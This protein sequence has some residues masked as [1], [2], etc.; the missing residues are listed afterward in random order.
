[1]VQTGSFFS[2]HSRTTLLTTLKMDLDTAARGIVRSSSS[3]EK[4]LPPVPPGPG[5]TTPG[6]TPSGVPGKSHHSKT[7]ER[8]KTM[9]VRQTASFFK[10]ATPEE[11]KPAEPAK[12]VFDTKRAVMMNAVMNWS[13]NLSRAK[14]L[15]ISQAFNKWKYG[16][17]TVQSAADGEP[18]KEAIGEQKNSYL[19]LFR[20]NEK[21]RQQL[22]ESRKTALMNEKSMR[23]S[24]MF[25][26]LKIILRSR[27]TAKQR[28]YYDIWLNNTKMMQLIGATNQRSV[29]LEVGLQQIDSERNYVQKMEQ[30]NS[31]L[32]FT[33]AM[34]VCF[35]KWK[36]RAAQLT[37]KEERSIYE[38]QRKLIFNELIR[39]R[40]I[41]STA[42]KQE[43]AVM[44]NAL[45]R[46][47]ELSHTLEDLKDQLVKAVKLGKST[48]PGLTSTTTSVTTFVTTAAGTAAGTANVATTGN[49]AN[50]SINIA[51]GNITASTVTGAIAAEENGGYHNDS[52]SVLT[53]VTSS[54][55]RSKAAETTR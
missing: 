12:P 34:T 11:Q 3:S 13:K 49:N 32:Q 27:T 51:G 28:Y 50:S 41:V 37:L 55:K 54:G 31:K 26:M 29:Q 21:L 40:K 35:Y 52:A 25:S 9:L 16:L 1:M 38:K 20:E 43:V 45:I 17:A 42:N 36:G 46:G 8:H 14:V 48:T 4:L 5:T 2:S 44:H 30:L 15:V 47:E 53:G 6:G 19:L 23:D 22:N 33:L 39:I 7:R 24:A 18:K 10:A